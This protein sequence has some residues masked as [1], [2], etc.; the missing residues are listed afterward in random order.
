MTGSLLLLGEF[1]VVEVVISILV[2]IIFFSP[3]AHVLILV[4]AVT[5]SL[6][7]AIC[8]G[9]THARLSSFRR[10]KLAPR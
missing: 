10:Y 8:I 5:I 6:L 1:V 3:L 2:D 4:M 7:T 9:I